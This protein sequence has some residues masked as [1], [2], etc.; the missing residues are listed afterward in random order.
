MI[1][2]EPEFS[3][4][5]TQSSPA[6]QRRQA[7]LDPVY[8]QDRI[9][10]AAAR[11]AAAANQPGEPVQEPQL[12]PDL[13]ID[14]GD[15]GPEIP[16]SPSYAGQGAA[17]ASPGLPESPGR[18][19][20]L[21]WI[22]IVAVCAFAV[23]M[24]LLLLVMKQSERP[25]VADADLPVVA[26]EE[27]PEKVRPADEG[28]MQPP[29]QDVAIYEKLSGEAKSQTEVLL[30][31]PEAPMPLP[32]AAP[33][34]TAP[35]ASDLSP[36]S[37]NDIPQ[38]PAPAFDVTDDAAAAASKVEPSAGGGTA[39]EAAPETPA[40]PTIND[41]VEQTASLGPAYRVQLA[42]VKTKDGA[43]ATW[44]KLQK[45]HGQLLSGKEL[46]VVEIDKGAEGK[47]YRV[48]AGPF[49]DRAAATDACMALKKLEQGCM[50]VKP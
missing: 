30:G 6:L 27:G 35:A 42:A 22:G 33:A 16:P 18:T 50:V 17:A 12:F 38:V 25:V 34:V 11:A 26:A 41:V 5:P 23:F 3:P 40:A 46:T 13:A 32:P 49:A 21:L 37:S 43:Q 1:P 10:T 15:S 4:R 31:Q 24:P 2:K 48:Q 14:D 44:D 8:S 47:F 36:S 29:N 45:K 28:G 7:V 19:R 20:P 9:L 39:G